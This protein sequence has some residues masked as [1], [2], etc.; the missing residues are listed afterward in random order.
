MDRKE[1]AATSVTIDVPN[2][3]AYQASASASPANGTSV[4]DSSAVV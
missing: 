2:G 1:G 4:R 3:N